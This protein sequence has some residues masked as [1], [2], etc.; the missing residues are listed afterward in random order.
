MRLFLFL[1]S[2]LHEKSF[3]P[4]LVGAVDA[5]YGGLNR[6]G[7]ARRPTG[8]HR[9]AC[10]QLRHGRVLTPRL[11]NG[12]RTPHFGV[13]RRDR[14]LHAQKSTYRRLAGRSGRARL[15][16]ADTQGYNKTRCYAGC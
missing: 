16:A 14:T 3:Y 15:C 2:N 5:L 4:I 1:R 11:G 13:D 7:R 12:E 9:G 10:A 6:H 8:A